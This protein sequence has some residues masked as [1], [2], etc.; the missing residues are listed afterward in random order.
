QRRIIALR[1]AIALRAEAG[2]AEM[3]LLMDRKGEVLA[4]TL[5][6]WPEGLL[7]QGDGFT[8]DPAQ[9]ITR[10]GER[11]LTVARELPGGFPLLLGRSLQPM[12]DTLAALRHGMLALLIGVL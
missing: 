12:D 7:R 8:I 6:G 3:T 5:P 1:E 11:W 2:G 10:G 4:G 9:E